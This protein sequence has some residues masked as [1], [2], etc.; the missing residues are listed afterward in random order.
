MGYCGPGR[1]NSEYEEHW[2]EV[3]CLYEHAAQS[4]L[5]LGGE[6]R[7]RSI[8]EWAID[9]THASMVMF[10]KG[11]QGPAAY[12]RFSP[13]LR[14]YGRRLG[15]RLVVEEGRWPQSVTSGEELPV[16]LVWR[17]L[18]NAPP[19]VDFAVELCLLTAKGQLVCRRVM[20]PPQVCTRK[21]L[22]FLGASWTRSLLARGRSF[23]A[24]PARP[25][26]A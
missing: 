5:D 7:V 15:Y 25:R 9:R 19:Y 12:S 10:G 18:G 17:N 21:W 11:A 8:L 16:P 20:E 24:R 1:T 14:E 4:W 23:A 22:P 26:A 3:L 2:P 6:Q 13:L